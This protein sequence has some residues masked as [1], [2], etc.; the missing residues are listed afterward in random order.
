MARRPGLLPWPVLALAAVSFALLAVPVASA[1][2]SCPPGE[3]IK[4]ASDP[5]VLRA[6]ATSFATATI[7]TLLSLALGTPL[8]YALSRAGRRMRSVAEAV[9]AVPVLLPHSAAGV[10]LLSVLGPAS[11]FRG[12]RDIVLDA[13]LGIIAA[14]AFVSAPLLIFSAR[15][16]F[17]D[18][19]VDLELAARSLG[20]SRLRTFFWVSLPLARRGILAGALLTWARA[21]SEF[22][23]VVVLAYY[24]MTVPVLVYHRFLAWGLRGSQPVVALL[25]LL[26]AVI[27]ACLTCL[28]VSPYGRGGIGRVSS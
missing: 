18:V 27:L 19:P 8:A 9:L 21:L 1:F 15:A 2:I 16:A 11:P 3:L 20:A 13:P 17:D 5:E 12:L 22:G 4:V 23:A 6:L 26:T 24:P 25:V 14:Q 10:A 7:T 28:G